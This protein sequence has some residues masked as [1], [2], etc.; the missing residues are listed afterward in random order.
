M[1]IDTPTLVWCIAIPLGIMT[2]A[3]VICWL[4]DKRASQ[5]DDGPSASTVMLTATILAFAWW[6]SVTLSLRGS[7]SLVLW[8]EDAWPRMI[9]PMLASVLLLSPHSTTTVRNQPWLWVV[10]AWIAVVAASLAMPSGEAWVDMFPLHRLWIAAITI[11]TT[12]NSFALQGMSDRG[13]ARW[14]PLVILA[15][16]ACAAITGA[17]TYGALLQTCLGAIVATVAVAAFA[18][19]SLIPSCA[20]IVFPSVLF[21]TTMIAAGRFYSYADIS[22]LAYGLALFAPGLI[23]VA[24]CAVRDKSV[25]TRVS[26]AGVMAIAI[27][28][29][30]AYR[31][32]IA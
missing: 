1:L 25:P 26:I 2:F 31:F 18:I 17:A 27:V 23:A 14:L 13:A 9:W 30:T 8:A 20:A 15:G 21:M 3:A 22:P 7:G 16:L 32:L 6:L 28:T 29:A 10:M 19:L 4:I 24:D 11:A 5:N 12:F